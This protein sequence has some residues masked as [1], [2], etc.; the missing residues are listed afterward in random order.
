MVT[1]VTYENIY[2]QKL[3]MYVNLNLAYY[4]NKIIYVIEV[5][6]TDKSINKS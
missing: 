6:S 2:C 3:C 5:R 4:T 1:K